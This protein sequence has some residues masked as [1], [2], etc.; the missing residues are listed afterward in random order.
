MLE[1]DHLLIDKPYC[2]VVNLSYV[3]QDSFTS[4][5]RKSSLLATSGRFVFRKT[6]VSMPTSKEALAGAPGSSRF[7][8]GA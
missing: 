1:L 7:F 3:L 8:F 4:Q 2:N 5:L 6:P